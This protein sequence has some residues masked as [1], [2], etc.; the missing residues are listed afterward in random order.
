MQSQITVNNTFNHLRHAQ[1]D[2]ATQQRQILNWHAPIRI[3]YAEKMINYRHIQ[4]FRA[5]MTTG[6]MTL[7][8][9]TLHVTQPAVS[10]LVREFEADIGMPLFHRSGNRV[11]ATAEAKLLLAEVERSYVGMTRI[12]SFANALRKGESG[13]LTIAAMPAMELGF[14][15]RFVAKFMKERPGLQVSGEGHSSPRVREKVA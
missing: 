10:R 4:A 15:P 9:Q 8:A 14:L 7:A 13:P 1:G 12:S 2:L 6:G 5:V 11:T 3:C